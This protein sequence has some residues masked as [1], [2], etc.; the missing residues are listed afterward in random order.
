MLTEGLHFQAFRAYASRAHWPVLIWYTIRRMTSLPESARLFGAVAKSANL[1][2]QKVITTPCLRH[3]I[4]GLPSD[5]D[6]SKSSAPGCG[7]PPEVVP[8]LLQKRSSWNR[9]ILESMEPSKPNCEEKCFFLPPANRAMPYRGTLDIDIPSSHHLRPVIARLHDLPP[10]Y[11][12]FT[13]HLLYS[14]HCVIYV[15]P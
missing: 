9:E 2:A 1:T 14:H 15:L 8:G 4:S 7:L 10:L 12:T 6:A 13:S 3:L 11:S 5:S